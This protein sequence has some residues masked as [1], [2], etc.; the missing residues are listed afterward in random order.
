[1]YFAPQVVL[2]LLEQGPEGG[3]EARRVDAGGWLRVEVAPAE[4]VDAIFEAHFG[5]ERVEVVFGRQGSGL[6]EVEMRHQ[7]AQSENGH[8]PR[9]RGALQ[10]PVQQLEF[11]GDGGHLVPRGLGDFERDVRGAE[12][13]R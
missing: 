7:R 6:C 3:H 1:M 2:L 9:A 5:E 8:L 11:A 13:A 10:E 12:A 4:R